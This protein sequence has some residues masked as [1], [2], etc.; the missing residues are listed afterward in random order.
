MNRI[1]SFFSF[2]LLFGMAEAHSPDVSSIALVRGSNNDWSI[3][4]N[5]SLSAFQYELQLFYPETHLDSVGP[6][7]F[8]RLVILY[9]KEKIRLRV[10]DQDRITY[11]NAAVR[12]GHETDVK[13]EIMG[14]PD[15]VH[16]IF[17]ENL[18][19]KEVHHHK[20]LGKVVVDGDHSKPFVLEEGNQYQISLSA[21]DEGFQ[22]VS[23]DGSQIP[24]I[25]AACLLV[26][27]M[28]VVMLYVKGIHARKTDQIVAE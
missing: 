26:V 5:A 1:V 7:D 18:S 10:N 12:L 19:F 8:Q 24:I 25:A 17:L 9:L 20:C 16:A 3:Q 4:V 2:L 21:T 28:L 27:T 14:M 13:L 23:K 6:E 15:E 22:E 11:G